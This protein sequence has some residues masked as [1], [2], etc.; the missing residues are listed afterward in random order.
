MRNKYAV[1]LYSFFLA[2]VLFAC[3]KQQSSQRTSDRAPAHNEISDF[4][5]ESKP[6]A[7]EPKEENVLSAS[8][9]TTIEWTDLMP[10]E[11]LNALLNPPSYISEIEDGSEQDQIDSQLRNN[12]GNEK[13]DRYQRAL[14][15]TNIIPEMNGS[16]VRIPGFIVPLE[17]DDEQTITQFFLVPFFGACLHLPPPPPNQIILVT[18]ESGFTLEALYDPFW[19][20]GILETSLTE[21]DIAT[22]AYT[23]KMHFIEMYHD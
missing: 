9:F 7:S 18:S 23:M 22:A 21:N 8:D 19:I 10:E 12:D 6:N 20:S 2:S 13:A 17:F 16:A 11:D 3:D 4:A 14:N 15:S 5:T 1:L